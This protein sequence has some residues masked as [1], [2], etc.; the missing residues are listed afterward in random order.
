MRFFL[1]K[2]FESFQND[3]FKSPC[4]EMGLSE[5]MSYPR[6]TS[7]ATSYVHD[8]ERQSNVDQISSLFSNYYLSSPTSNIDPTTSSHFTTDS[9]N[10][11]FNLQ[12]YHYSSSQLIRVCE[13]MV[14][15]DAEPS[16]L[17][18]P[19]VPPSSYYSTSYVDVIDQGFVFDQQQQQQHMK[20]QLNCNNTPRR[21]NFGVGSSLNESSASE[22]HSAA[23]VG[24][25]DQT[26]MFNFDFENE[27][28]SS[29]QM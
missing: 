22:S 13:N 19:P 8:D 1:I 26:K 11:Y 15:S 9:S 10:P 24:D 25:Y 4:E 28:K 27:S 18:P 3:L 20:Q 14:M 7:L 17:S 23:A 2:E 29:R 12:P 5:C 6:E 16:M 21:R